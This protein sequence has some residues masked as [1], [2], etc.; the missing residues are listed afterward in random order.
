MNILVDKVRY[1]QEIRIL[2]KDQQ[3]DDEI[4]TIK[5]QNETIKEQNETIKE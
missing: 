1:E 2:K 4:K 5:E 3:K